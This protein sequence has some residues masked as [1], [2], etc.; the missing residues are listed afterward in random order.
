MPLEA[1]DCSRK[2]LSEDN[3]QMPS[4]QKPGYGES[5][6]FLSVGRHLRLAGRFTITVHPKGYQLFCTLF[7]LDDKTNEVSVYTAKTLGFALD[8]HLQ[9]VHPYSFYIILK[10]IDFI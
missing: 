1:R 7:R 5:L 8:Q 2:C 3:E 9:S 10:S 4:T 6:L